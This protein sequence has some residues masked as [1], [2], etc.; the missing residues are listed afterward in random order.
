MA[1]GRLTDAS[2]TAVREGARIDQVVAQY[3]T[4]KRAGTS[5]KG[6]CPFHDEK[7]P[8][9]HVTPDRGYFHCFGCN[10]GGDVLDFIQKIES[11]DFIES[12]ERLADQFRIELAYEDAQGNPS[13]AAPERAHNRAA[14]GRL[15]AANTAAVEFYTA[16][17]MTPEAVEARRFLSERGFDRHAAAEFGCGYS[18]NGWDV[19]IKHLTGQGFTLAELSD[20]GLVSEGKNG[21]ID[22]FRA[23][24]MFPIRD[25][26]GDVIGFG[27]RKL[28]PDDQ[29]KGPKYLNTSETPLYKKSKVLFGL[30]KARKSISTTRRVV[31]VEGYTDVMACHLSGE[32]TAVATCGTAF[33]EEHIRIIRR[34]LGDDGSGGEVIYTFD[35]DAAGKKAA[36]RAFTMDDHFQ[37]RTSVAVEPDGMD[38]CEVRIKRGSQGVQ[39]LLADRIPLFEF[40]IKSTLGQFDLSA[41]EGRANALDEVAPILSN[42]KHAEM[43]EAY[44]RNL[45]RWTGMDATAIRH[46][47][48]S[49]DTPAVAPAPLRP[50]ATAVAAAPTVASGPPDLFERPH[51]GVLALSATRDALKAML[52]DLKF[53]QMGREELHRNDIA[54]PTYRAV[55]DA[56]SQAHAAGVTEGTNW[57]Q[58]VHQHASSPT[59]AALITELAVEPYTR[60]GGLTRTGAFVTFLSAITE[61]TTLA[62]DSICQ[63]LAAP[64]LTD[65]RYASLLSSLATAEKR[66]TFANQR[67]DQELLGA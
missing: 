1:R 36:L 65:E 52:Q 19:L 29:D 34:L 41:P 24:L 67:R 10:E 37:T 28:L 25:Q 8:S 6:L 66:R 30:D 11:L 23:R 20:A 47:T 58:A 35:G 45:S 48:L 49:T 54:H 38:P 18:P 14:R 50:A 31:V 22:R 3:V 53:V 39:D 4:L 21:H 40:A 12:I 15:L 55:Y 46:A 26:S 62:V 32:T 64:G 61:G 9:F 17:L 44:I 56:I 33:G 16:Q 2:I 51:P 27:A 63:A 60:V 42:L 43:R 5:L 7:G 59:V 57:V 13:N